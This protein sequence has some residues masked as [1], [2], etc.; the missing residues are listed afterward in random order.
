MSDHT[1]HAWRELLRSRALVWIGAA[2]LFLC[3]YFA[4]YLQ[5]QIPPVLAIPLGGPSYFVLSP[6]GKTVATLLLGHPYNFLSMS[7]DEE[8]LY[9]IRVFDV[10]TGKERFVLPPKARS[11]N[12]IS[13]SPD[14][15]LIT[16]YSE[17]G[18]LQVLDVLTGTIVRSFSTA[19]LE[20]FRLGPHFAPDSIHFVLPDGPWRDERTSNWRPPGAN[21]HRSQTLFNCKTGQSEGKIQGDFRTLFFSRDGERVATWQ[22]DFGS[23]LFHVR[24][25]NGVKSGRLTLLHDQEIVADQVEFTSDLKT[26]ATI[27]RAGPALTE[28]WNLRDFATGKVLSTFQYDGFAGARVSTH[29]APDGTFLLLQDNRYYGEFNFLI[30]FGTRAQKNLGPYTGSATISPD[31]KWYGTN[32]PDSICLHKLYDAPDKSPESCLIGVESLPARLLYRTLGLSERSAGLRFSSHGRF[33]GATFDSSRTFTLPFEN[34]IPEQWIRLPKGPIPCTR[35]RVWDL[36]RQKELLNAQDCQFWCFS[37]DETT[38]AAIGHDSNLRLWKLTSEKSSN[39]VFVTALVYWIAAAGILWTL[40]ALWQK[41]PLKRQL[42]S[43]LHRA[44]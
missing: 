32:A 8:P 20:E 10:A 27:R 41:R 40:R 44:S 4:L 30:G 24:V 42:L 18:D 35:I 25:W 12:E 7:G 26:L 38:L 37:E 2:L 23:D 21:Q 6:D 34:W 22:K 13:F 33:A 39:T 14:G 9:P 29:E 3:I 1:R 15:R 19:N 28:E 16:A 43:R 31:C 5:S 17:K 36:E 11:L